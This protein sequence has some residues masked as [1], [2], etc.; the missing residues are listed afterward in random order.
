MRIPGADKAIDNLIA[1]SRREE[2]APLREQVLADHF[3]E[4]FDQFGLTMDGIAQQLG[5]H[6]ISMVLG[7]VIEDFFTARFGG[8]GANVIDDYLHR[9]GWKE[10]VPAR[11]YLEALRDSTLSLYEV[12]DLVPGRQMSVKDLIRGGEPV[13]VDEKLGSETA[14]RWDCIAA[15][16]VTVNGQTH[17]TGGMLLFGRPLAD[18]Y[19]ANLNKMLTAAKWK[20]RAEVKARGEM[21]GAGD[22]EFRHALLEGASPM[23]VQM[24]LA[25]ALERAARPMPDV[26]NYDGDEIVFA[27]VRF[28]MTGTAAEVAGRLDACPDLDRD[29]P[30]DRRWTWLE[31]ATV[32]QEASPSGTAS[33]MVT[34]DTRG[35]SG[36]RV[37]GS[38]DIKDR[39]VILSTNS[40]RRAERGQ[41]LVASVLDGLVGQ[42]M[43]SLQSL[44]RALEERRDMPP[45][46]PPLP[47][48]AAAEVLRTYFDQ[49]YRETLDQ[50]IPFFDGKSPRQ[51]ARTKKGRERVVAWLKHLENGDARRASHD[52]QPPYD[53]SWMWEELGVGKMRG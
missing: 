20:M 41:A 21:I 36:A 50:P 53:F 23:F 29:A 47:P 52:G 31:A 9:R 45:A 37:L 35:D 28:P 1:W 10:K 22:D 42:P 24:W 30:D 32:G 3:D 5:E 19:L 15:R 40:M 26:R 18:E 17:F 7:C 25:D 11:R 33:G 46:E 34:W 13:V 43:T 39:S 49:H 38:I 27:E 6:A 51:A 48:E 12:V 4:I 8:D 16:V 14:A 44:N 2:W